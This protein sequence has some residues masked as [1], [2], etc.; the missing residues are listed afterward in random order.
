MIKQKVKIVENKKDKKSEFLFIKLKKEAILLAENED[1]LNL[2]QK[3][4]DLEF[5][6]VQLKKKE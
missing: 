2:I 4:Q 6:Q 5:L 3:C 1:E